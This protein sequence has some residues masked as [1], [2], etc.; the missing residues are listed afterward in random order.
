M[1][2][3]ARLIITL[4]LIAYVAVAL[5][6][7]R[8]R[9]ADMMCRGIH[10]AVDD[11]KGSHFVTAREVANEL[12][13]LAKGSSLK[14]LSAI[15]TDSVER[16]LNSIDKIEHAT[17]TTLTDGSINISVTP[18]LPVARV[19][20]GNHSYYINKDGKY[21]SAT[22]RYHTDV[23]V[24][25]GNFSDRIKPVDLLPILNYLST[26]SAWSAM[27]TSIKV[28]GPSNIIL[29]PMIYGHVINLG[30]TQ[31]LSDKFARLSRAYREILPVKGW[32]Y[33]DTLSVKW[34]GQ[35]VAT[36]R[37]K[38]THNGISEADF[39]A[40]AELPDLGTMLVADSTHSAPK[41]KPSTPTHP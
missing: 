31:G 15:N 7:T 26:D 16:L 39:E 11:T 20:D 32:N 3:I 35:I 14:R 25:Y 21:I 1:K 27:V 24:I 41:S 4:L 29:V 28:D 12:G 5:A 33:Y 30:D 9:S 8:S 19:F 23:P 38:A 17:L 36:R 6:W 37:H 34:R 2:K 13:P 22:A 40:E 10:I 18:M